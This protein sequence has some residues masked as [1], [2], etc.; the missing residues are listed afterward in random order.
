MEVW[1][2][3]EWDLE[4]SSVLAVHGKE[5]DA[6]A[7]VEAHNAAD[8]FNTWTRKHISMRENAAEWV[9]RGGNR[10]IYMRRHEVK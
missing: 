7:F 6:V 5:C 2:S 8:E 9:T 3:V 1:V 4:D 10:G